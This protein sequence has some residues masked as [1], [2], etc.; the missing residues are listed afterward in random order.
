[1]TVQTPTIAVGSISPDQAC[2]VISIQHNHVI[3]AIGPDFVTRTP[4]SFS[5]CE[6]LWGS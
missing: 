4:I 2:K 3:V 5:D 6:L 1:V